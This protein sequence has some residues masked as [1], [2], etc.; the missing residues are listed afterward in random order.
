VT[1]TLRVVVDEAPPLSVTVSVTVYVPAA[2]YV[3]DG[4][5]AVDVP[6]SPNAQER[7]AIVPS[8][9]VLPSVNVHV[10]PLHD[11]V[12]AAVGAWLVPPPPPVMKPVY[13]SRFGDPDPGLLTTPVV[14]LA[15]SAPATADGDADRLPSR[16]RAAA[17]ATCGDD[18]DVPDFVAL[19]VFDVFDADTML[20]PGANRSTHVP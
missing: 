11:G 18:I 17:P 15:T 7:E 1:V 12:K 19:P 8:A 4:L 16:Y 6:P 10:R 5:V 14:A 20:E 2:A 3:C 9:S 13:R